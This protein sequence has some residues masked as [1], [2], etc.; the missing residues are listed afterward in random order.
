MPWCVSAGRH[1]TDVVGLEIYA[2]RACRRVRCRRCEGE[3]GTC[4][5][6]GSAAIESLTLADDAYL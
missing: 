5:V 3:Y 2:C 1:G 4:R 6:C